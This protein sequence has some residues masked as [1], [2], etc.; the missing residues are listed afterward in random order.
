MKVTIENIKPKSGEDF[1]AR[2]LR[3]KPTTDP[4]FMLLVG[5]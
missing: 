3:P 4:K 1:R 2:Y 5:W